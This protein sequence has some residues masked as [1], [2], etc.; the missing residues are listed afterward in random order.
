MPRSTQL[1]VSLLAI[2]LLATV[3]IVAGVVIRR[4]GIQV[5]FTQGKADFRQ[6]R[7]A[8]ALERLGRVA[9]A[10]PR[11]VEVAYLLGACEERLNRPEAAVAHWAS[12]PISSTTGPKAALS[13]ARI[14]IHGLGRLK[15]AEQLLRTV[16]ADASGSRASAQWLLSEVLVWEG[17]LDEVR[18]LLVSAWDGSQGMDRVAILREHWRLD[19]VV[20]AEDEMKPI[21]DAAA[22]A[23]RKDDRV[24][25]VRASLATR[26]GR[27]DE[28]KR[29]LDA[30]RKAAPGDPV[31]ARLLLRWALDADRP[32]EAAKA[33]V[34]LAAKDLEPR[35]ILA[36]RAWNARRRNDA[37][38]ERRALEEQ[39]RLRPDDVAA[40]DRLH[41][42]ARESG[43]SGRDKELR[44]R[45]IAIEQD[46]EKY[47]W[48]LINLPKTLAEVPAEELAKNAERLG[49][50]F[51][52]RGWWTLA[53]GQ[54]PDSSEP[55]LALERLANHANESFAAD[56]EFAA[57]KSEFQV[58]AS[59]RLARSDAEDMP[60]FVNG[61]DESGL[62]FV[63]RTG[64]SPE[65]Q[66]PETMG[67]GV[68]LLDYDGDGFVDVYLVQG[69]TFA[70]SRDAPVADRLFRNRGDGTF[71]DATAQVHLDRMPGGY[72]HGVAVGDFDNDGDP[73]L[74]VTRWRSYA[75]YRNR[76]DG[77]F[78][79]ATTEAGLAGDRDW[80]TSAAFADLDNDGDLDLYVCH[81]LAWDAQNPL[82]CRSQG[83]TGS[84]V[85]CLPLQ[86][87][88]MPDHVFRNDAGRFVDVT[89]GSG[90]VD[91]DGRG[92][93]VVAVD[94]TNDGRV[95][96]FVA[97]DQ[98]ANRFYVN[99]GGMKFEEVG[100][101]AGLACGAD[102]V[103]RAGMGVACGDV[104]GDGKIDLAVTNFFGESMTLFRNLG[105]GDFAD[106]TS[107]FGLQAP[108]RFLLGFGAAFVDV[109]NDGSLD[110]ATANGHVNE[111]PSRFPYAMP[112]QL[113]IGDRNGRLRDVSVQAG[114]PWN[115][116]VVGRGLATGDLD[117]DGDVDVVI[118]PQE[119][120]TLLASNRTRG[121]H[122][123]T[124]A[125]EGT[126][127]NRDA[128][129]ARVTV[130]AGE[131]RISAWR[132]GGGSY[133][134]ASE[135]RL[136]FGLGETAVIDD[137]EVAW[138]SGDVEHFR[139]CEADAAY[140]IREGEPTVRRLP[141]FEASGRL[142]PRPR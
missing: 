28:A 114:P 94:L 125:L 52:A 67:G 103:Y 81:Y 122:F 3:G 129:G 133:Q 63:Y 29:W 139:G 88:A 105:G 40:L 4:R 101:S 45:K 24:W 6:R 134:S 141:G 74:F 32:D 5:D 113:L 123:L 99:R 7:Y 121:G 73:D 137:V 58:A 102:G 35:E 14:L 111:D 116:P 130:K 51:E 89:E 82:I 2:V 11:D 70:P 23:A 109:N 9:K 136:H 15:E 47:R 10:W 50:D 75:L 57:L 132:V 60:K 21:L 135:G 13:R 48:L 131:R 96:L 1:R 128:V 87:P 100:A 84:V 54:S 49:R 120:P 86:F 79:D 33:L 77:T 142:R 106:E 18:R 22:K 19:R 85:S 41:V 83:A 39:L 17:R 95:D 71:L 62:S 44:E 69:G 12:I 46:R 126:R 25:L 20:V 115:Q 55:R 124:I 31:V 93:G 34:P 42:M 112:S 108:S 76:G 92:L 64:K 78:E 138:P 80:P 26:Y 117:N 66:L 72:G 97:N 107:A 30:C 90:I 38:G 59:P 56:A 8:E 140:R 65:R 110:L 104:D 118:V 91:T 43:E 27:F 68:G 37:V 127:S 119:S 53:Q 98:T 36:L 61:A 16:R